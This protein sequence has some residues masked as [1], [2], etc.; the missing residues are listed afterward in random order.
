VV[1]GVAKRASALRIPVVAVV[2]DV[3]DDAYAVYDLGVTA[4]FSTNRKAIP[5]S[6]ARLRSAQDLSHTLEDVIRFSKIF[7]NSR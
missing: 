1:A 2:G 5:F 4:I 7:R 3:A 6:E